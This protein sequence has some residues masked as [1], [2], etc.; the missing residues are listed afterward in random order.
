MI[1]FAPLLLVFHLSFA[2]GEARVSCI[3]ISSIEKSSISLWFSNSR[4]LAQVPGTIGVRVAT[5]GVR[6]GR[7]S[8]VAR[9]SIG[10]GG[11]IAISSIQKSSISLW[12][13]ISRP[14]AQVPGTIGVA[15]IGVR[16]GRVSIG[17]GG[18]IA[19]S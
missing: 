17:E 1:L 14:L 9:V 15:T 19:I 3:A 12:F 7:V 10:V 4:P 16:V 18:S 11:S 5:I 6:V 2:A 13:S 8:G